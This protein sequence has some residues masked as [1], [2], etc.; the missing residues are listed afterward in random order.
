MV[1]IGMKELRTKTDEVVKRVQAGEHFRVMNRN[2]PLFDIIPIEDGHPDDTT[3]VE[4]YTRAYV[5]DNIEL[6]KSLADK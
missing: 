4:T 5:R 3:E 6:F 1:L 2:K